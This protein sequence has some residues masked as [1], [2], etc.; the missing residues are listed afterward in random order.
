MLG[1]TAFLG[2][3][4]VECATSRGHTVT[5]FNRGETNPEAFP[6]LENLRGDR[7]TNLR[8][9]EGRTWDA[10]IDTSGR[11]PLNVQASVALLRDSVDHYCF[12]SS[13]TVYADLSTPDVDESAPLVDV[14][15]YR[16]AS[17]MT[18][19]SYGPFKALC[20]EAV[21]RAFDR[22]ALIARPGLILGPHDYTNRSSYWVE[23]V[24]E[25][26]EILAPGSSDRQIQFI[27]GRDLAKWLIRMAET[28]EGGV[29]NVT[30][31]DFCLT[32]GGFLEAIA[33]ILPGEGHFTWVDEAFL[34][35]QDVAYWSEL[36]LWLPES[37][38]WRLSIDKALQSGLE[39]RPLADTLSD[40]LASIGPHRHTW[41]VESVWSS[42]G[43]ALVGLE[44]QREVD[45]LSQ[46]HQR[47]D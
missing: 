4:V 17:R 7:A 14:D 10:V 25:A 30:G 36:P 1:G 2:R 12:V 24:A 31:P 16:H 13:L 28:A 6:E 47:S 19:E 32:M 18:P 45:L 11:M 39:F 3:H 37:V 26:G 22:Q 44:R 34:A 15:P 35:E 41:P 20:E 33:S 40:V 23:R 5:L 9:L 46:W 21:L 38:P 43:T 27:D 42:G 8:A 29:Y